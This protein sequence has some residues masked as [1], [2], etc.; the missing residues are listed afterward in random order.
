LPVPS[1]RKPSFPS[2][3][4]G[5]TAAVFAALAGAREPV[6]AATIASDFRRGKNVEKQIAA[7]LLSLVR[8]GHIS[9]ANGGS[10][11]EIRRA[12]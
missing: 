10:K 1:A 12:A 5:Q 9:V 7:V 2:D 4:V 6:D 8:L 3:A 11:F